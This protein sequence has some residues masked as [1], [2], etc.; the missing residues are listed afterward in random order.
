MMTAPI[1]NRLRRALGIEVVVG[2]VVLIISSWLVSLTPPGLVGG[3]GPK[4]DI[5]NP[6]R[7]FNPGLNIDVSVAFGEKVGINDVRIE[8]T[9]PQT[10]LSGLAVEFDPPQGSTANGMMLDNIPLTG[11]GVAVLSKST[12]FSLP[13]S[14][15]WTLVVRVGTTV[16]NKLDVFVS[17]VGPPTTLAPRTT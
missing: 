4:L 8:V 6:H 5:R 1:A 7:F 12:G 15:T 3:G 9:S 13:A 10:G 2:I 11:K 16:V 14:G 17:D